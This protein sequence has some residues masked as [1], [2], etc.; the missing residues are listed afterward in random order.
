[1]MILQ[2]FL[3]LSVIGLFASGLLVSGA[4]IL[5]FGQEPTTDFGPPV[6][7]VPNDM[8]IPVTNNISIP[9]IFTVTAVDD[10]DGNITPTCSP[11]SGSD[12][13]IGITTVTCT[14]TDAF[15]YTA[16]ESFTITVEYTAPDLPP[17]ITIPSNII[18]ETDT[19]SPQS[20]EFTVTATD[21]ED[22]SITPECTANSGDSFDIDTTTVTCTATDSVGNITEESFTVTINYIAPDIPPPTIIV[23]S[24][25][26]LQTNTYS[27]TPIAFT[28]T[29]TDANGGSITPEC[30]ANYG[31]QF[32]IGFTMVTCSATDTGG[33][34]SSE[35]FKITITYSD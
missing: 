1:M 30:T 28:V 25:I 27:P 14:A 15:G 4:T 8:T 20:V 16:N 29:A 23:P 35:S 5:V 18:L 22:G 11:I 9:V 19:D 12:F 33:N 2:N 17:T 21:V 7:T 31:D 13:D 26:I 24:N 10:I 34:S 32:P 6:I 3:K